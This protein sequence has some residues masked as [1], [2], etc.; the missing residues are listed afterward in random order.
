MFATQEQN[1]TLPPQKVLTPIVAHLSS[2]PSPF[3]APNAHRQLH[4]QEESRKN[5]L[6]KSIL[7]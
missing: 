3:V 6:Q 2:A 7:D 5:D 4:Y 1:Q